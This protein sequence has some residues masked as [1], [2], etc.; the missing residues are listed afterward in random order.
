MPQIVKAFLKLLSYYP[1]KLRAQIP[2]FS[3]IHCLLPIA[4]VKLNNWN[5]LGEQGVAQPLSYAVRI[6]HNAI[7]FLDKR[8]ACQ[9]LGGVGDEPVLISLDAFHGMPVT[10]PYNSLIVTMLRSH[11]TRYNPGDNETV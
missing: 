4:P 3:G 10:V 6:D 9:L 2:E 1:V 8:L 11:I 7:C 5:A